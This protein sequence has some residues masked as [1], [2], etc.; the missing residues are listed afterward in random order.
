[1]APSYLADRR[2]AL[3]ADYL[4]PHG[5]ECPTSINGIGIHRKRNLL[6][7]TAATFWCA[8]SVLQD[9]WL[10]PACQAMI[11]LKAFA[12]TRTNKTPNADRY[13]QLL[14]RQRRSHESA[15]S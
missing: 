3:L 14:D 7:E 13:I 4:R 2:S 8:R 10:A 11:Y 1:M 5:L 6:R 9:I 12:Q 15:S